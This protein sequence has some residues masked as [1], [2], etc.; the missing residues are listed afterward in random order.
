[1]A[2]AYHVETIERITE[3]MLEEEIV[4]ETNAILWDADKKIKDIKASAIDEMGEIKPDAIGQIESIK[5]DA[6]AQIEKLRDD[7]LSY[8][9]NEKHDMI[10]KLADTV[11][12]ADLKKLDADTAEIYERINAVAPDTEAKIINDVRQMIVDNGYNVSVTN[13]EDGNV[14]VEIRKVV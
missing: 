7:Y 6:V 1:M 11:I 9:A 8:S 3:Q 12:R 2:T 10:S 13:D 14:T 4:S 5:D